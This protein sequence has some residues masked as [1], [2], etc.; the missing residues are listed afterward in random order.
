MTGP[1]PAVARQRVLVR[2]A[3][4]G[5]PLDA[6]VLVAC[7]GGADSLALAAATAFVAPRAG[8]R[9]GAV[10]VDHGLQQGSDAVAR[11]AAQQCAGLGLA[12]VL[13]RRVVV[14]PSGVHGG[15]EAA[16]RAARYAALEEVARSVGAATV[17]LGHTLDDQAETVLLGLARG[18][19]A[20]ALAGMPPRRGLVRRPFL[21]VRRSETEQACR[22]LGLEPWHDPTNGPGAAP[23]RSRVRHEVMPVL[24]GLLGPGVAEALART[25]DQL[26]GDDAALTHLAEGVLARALV[27]PTTAGATA[28]GLDLDVTVLAGAPDAVRR[29]ALRAA[30]V[31]AGVPDGALHRVHVLAVDALVTDWHG[32]GA[33]ALPGGRA[34]RRRCG[35]L[36]VCP[37]GA[38]DERGQEAQDGHDE[39][40]EQG[41]GATGGRG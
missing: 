35:R 6:L 3:L 7:S 31:R 26:A 15:P 22:A 34:A 38:Q 5:L 29:R 36:T 10:V 9:A 40:D 28:P 14:G 32:Q 1:D 25:A 41:R 13:A 27:P 39:H 2:R 23:L 21:G 37:A 33:V 17:L 19:G 20:R 24:E 8:L 30:L 12:P 11:A 18:S 16:A 4:A